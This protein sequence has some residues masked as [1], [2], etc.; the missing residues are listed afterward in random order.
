MTTAARD[1][2]VRHANLSEAAAD[3]GPLAN[4]AGPTTAAM[5]SM[6]DAAAR[7][8]S[9]RPG[10]AQAGAPPPGSPSQPGFTAA[11]EA[12]SDAAGAAAVG[13]AAARAVGGSAEAGPAGT[14]PFVDSTAPVDTKSLRRLVEDMR[15]RGWRLLVRL[16]VPADAQTSLEPSVKQLPLHGQVVCWQGGA[17]LDKCP[18]ARAGAH[19]SPCLTACGQLQATNQCG[20]HPR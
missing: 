17:S 15:R 1:A 5:R 11:S 14:G 13:G 19:C 3:A 10:S 18:G 4:A 12:T 9:S 6:I 20:A 7:A 2:A 8:G 16:R